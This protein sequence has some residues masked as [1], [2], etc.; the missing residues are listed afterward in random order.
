VVAAGLKDRSPRWVKDL[1][2]ASTRRYALATVSRRPAPDFLVIGTKRGGTTSLFNYLLM[3]PGPG[4]TDG[5]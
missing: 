1:A 2:N 4:T 5:G 3:H